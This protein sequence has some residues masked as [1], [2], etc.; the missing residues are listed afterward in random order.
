MYLTSF[1]MSHILTYFFSLYIDQFLFG[2]WPMANV[3][4]ELSVYVYKNIYN[5]P[6]NTY[7]VSI[8]LLVLQVSVPQWRC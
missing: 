4:F 3:V 7:Y 8:L 2:K 1:Y 5:V 6:T